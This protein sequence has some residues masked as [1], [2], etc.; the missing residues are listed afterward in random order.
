MYTSSCTPVS[1]QTGSLCNT[2][3]GRLDGY[4]RFVV[5]KGG[6][7]TCNGDSSHVHLQ[8]EVQGSIYDV[9]VDIGQTQGD[10][11]FYE[12]DRAIPVG[13]WAEGFHG[14]YALDYTSLGLHSGQGFT[15]QDPTTLG[16]KIQSELQG[17]N[18]IAV[19]GECYSPQG[20]GA[21]DVHYVGHGNDGAIVINPLAQQAHLLLFH[22]STQ[23][24]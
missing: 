18:H 2:L 20:N 21:H 9:A 15:P 6:S 12:E 5:P 24:F 23:T 14:T 1:Q 8:I 7:H 17:V 11:L 22:F 19:F 10:V 3:H 4:L 13:P 16:Q